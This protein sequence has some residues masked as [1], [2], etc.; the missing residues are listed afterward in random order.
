MAKS[1]YNR[2]KKQVRVY[3]PQ[4][5]PE[6]K[7]NSLQ[8][9]DK[10]LLKQAIK[11]NKPRGVQII[12]KMGY[13]DS[14]VERKAK[15]GIELEPF[16]YQTIDIIQTKDIEGAYLETLEALEEAI[17][18]GDG[19]INDKSSGSVFDLNQVIIKLID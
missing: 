3:T 4:Q 12:A 15:E 10:N 1:S 6:N 7:I 18:E 8:N 16:T 13:P 17:E 19:I 9:W 11:E 5:N 14:V 2:R